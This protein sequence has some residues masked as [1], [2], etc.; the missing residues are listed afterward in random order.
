MEKSESARGSLLKPTHVIIFM[1][2]TLLSLGYKEYR[3]SSWFYAPPLTKDRF[4]SR[5]FNVREIP[6]TYY[7]VGEL[8]QHIREWHQG[9]MDGYIH[10]YR[11][12]PD[13]KPYSFDLS[14]LKASTQ[15]E[16]F[17]E[18]CNHLESIVCKTCLDATEHTIMN[19]SDIFAAP[20]N[21]YSSFGKLDDIPSV[22]RLVDSIA[23]PDLDISKMTLEHAFIGNFPVDRVT[24]YLHGNSISS[25]M[26]VQFRGSKHW[27]FFSPEVFK[28]R[29]MIDAH[30]AAGIS[31]PSKAPDGPFDVYFVK[32]VPGDIIFF[33]ENWGHTVLTKAG[34]NVMFNFRKVQ[35][36][37]VL[38]RPFNW[39]I[40]A[41]NGFRFPTQYNNGRQRTPFNELFNVYI[42]KL[43]NLCSD[44][45][46][47]P[48]DADMLHLLK[49]GPEKK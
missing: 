21:Y 16:R 36:G 4:P 49:Y 39:L 6:V 7:K 37:N 8:G 12:A 34:P 22:K 25:S 10:I 26:S 2:A 47:A 20:T 17:M 44:G 30:P 41:T 46:L 23:I 28:N 18:P 11:V 13:S 45:T 19:V 33:S 29:D 24:A 31:V 35:L 1:L 5:S 43:H 42:E 15:V 3:R 9:S 48:W 14:L 32:T 27:L 40:A 38:R